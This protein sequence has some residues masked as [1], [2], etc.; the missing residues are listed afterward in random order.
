MP[1]IINKFLGI[2]ATSEAR[3]G[4]RSN[5]EGV[6]GG[7]LCLGNTADP[8]V[9]GRIINK[10]DQQV[11]QKQQQQQKSLTQSVRA[12]ATNSHSATVRAPP[13]AST[14]ALVYVLAR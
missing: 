12:A 5:R 8:I 11:E 13:L 2:T 7:G 10:A 6:R 1:Q 4:G 9:V 14:P 3:G